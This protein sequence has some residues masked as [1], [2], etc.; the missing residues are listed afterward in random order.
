M[1]NSSSTTGSTPSGPATLPASILNGSAAPSQN[2]CTANVS[3]SILTKAMVQAQFPAFKWANDK[4][5]TPQEMQCWAWLAT[6]SGNSHPSRPFSH[7]YGF[8]PYIL[9]QI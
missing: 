8:E 2:P 3:D 9:L 4:P 5:W 7:Q 1:G 6:K